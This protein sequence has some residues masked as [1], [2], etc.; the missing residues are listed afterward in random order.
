MLAFRII[1]KICIILLTKKKCVSK[2]TG[3][4][5]SVNKW[6]KVTQWSISWVSLPGFCWQVRSAV[7]KRFHRWQEQHSIRARMTQAMS[8]PTSPSRVSFHSI[9]QSTSLWERRPALSQIRALGETVIIFCHITG[10]HWNAFWAGARLQSRR[11][12][13]C[14]CLLNL[15]RDIIQTFR[16]KWMGTGVKDTAD[17]IKQEVSGSKD[18]RDQA[19]SGSV[20]LGTCECTALH[21]V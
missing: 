19:E 12:R 11:E 6:I 16:R 17:F 3:G 15:R 1:L 18:A 2:P 10:V 7:R 9:K 8:I 21:I 20:W 13:D 14:I 5:I 4:V